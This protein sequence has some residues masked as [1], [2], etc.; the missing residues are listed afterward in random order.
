MTSTGFYRIKQFE[1]DNASTQQHYLIMKNSMSK[2]TDA[3]NT[4]F[5]RGPFLIH[6]VTHIPVNHISVTHICL[7]ISKYMAVL[8]TVNKLTVVLRLYARNFTLDL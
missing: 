6:G 2:C 4:L 3:T 1:H 5:S 7:Y 8:Q